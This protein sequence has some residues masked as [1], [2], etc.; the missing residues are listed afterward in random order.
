MLGFVL[1]F[2]KMFS[3]FPVVENLGYIICSKELQNKYLTIGYMLWN[4]PFVI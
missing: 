3:L 4:T 1:S 2:T